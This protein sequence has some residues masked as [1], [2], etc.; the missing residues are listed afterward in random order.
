MS[1]VHFLITVVLFVLLTPGILVRLP[2]KGSKWTVAIVHGTVFAFVMH[3][4]CWYILPNLYNL[5]GL[6]TPKCVS[7]C[8]NLK[9]TEHTSCL[10]KCGWYAQKN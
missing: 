5:E 7:T 3:I 2:P 10:K 9:G 8:K 1:I 4:V 6:W